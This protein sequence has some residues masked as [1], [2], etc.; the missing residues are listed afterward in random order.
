MKKITSILLTGALA[1][2]GIFG[3]TGTTSYAEET[4]NPEAQEKYDEK[5]FEDYYDYV[6]GELK[7]YDV[8]DAT[9]SK[10]IKKLK[11]KEK[12]DSL[13]PEMQGTATP[14]KI[15]EET[16][17]YV[18][19]DGSIYIESLSGGIVEEQATSS[20]MTVPV[21]PSSGGITTMGSISGGTVSSGSG[22]T[23]VKGAEVVGTVIL[24]GASYKV[25]YTIVNGGYDTISA[26]YSRNITVPGPGGDYTV[27]AWGVKKA[28]EDLNG[29]AYVALRFKAQ[30]DALGATTLYLNTYVGNNAAS[31]SSNM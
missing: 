1:L 17:K 2:S 13:N 9:I 5:A 28:K 8:P 7:K 3:I 29:K 25:D 27:E 30:N 18:Y 6:R 21:E 23:V 22:Y 24:A 12:W 4:K 26:A 10:L 31:V 15:D 19:S 20:G 11:N 14:V 16:T